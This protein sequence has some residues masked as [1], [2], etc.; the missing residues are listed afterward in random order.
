MKELPLLCAASVVRNFLNVE[1]GS[2]PPR[3]IDSSKPMQWQDRRPTKPQPN[4]WQEAWG[5]ETGNPGDG[6]CF[7]VPEGTSKRILGTENFIEYFCPAKV[8]DV[9][10]VRES[11]RAV[12]RRFIFRADNPNDDQPYKPSLHMPKWTSRIHLE[13]MRVRVERACD[14]SEQDAVAEGVMS[15]WLQQAGDHLIDAEQ[16]LFKSLWE[17]LYGPDAWEKFVWVYD[18]KRIK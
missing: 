6:R 5:H 7:W 16:Y 9:F 17:K 11:F 13:V 15:Y 10:Y 3:A 12:G 1:V 4:I 2:W 8:G 18:L 14:I